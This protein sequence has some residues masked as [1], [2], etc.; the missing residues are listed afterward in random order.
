MS[1][2]T[3]PIVLCDNEDGCTNFEIDW[4]GTGASV[5]QLPDKWTGTRDEAR[6]PDCSVD[7]S[8]AGS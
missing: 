7:E 5:P 4:Y 3:V 2:G 6:C 1:L 8:E